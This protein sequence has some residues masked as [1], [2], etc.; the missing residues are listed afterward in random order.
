MKIQI[1][2]SIFYIIS[3]TII[4]NSKFSTH[5]KEKVKKLGLEKCEDCHTTKSWNE[6]KTPKEFDHSKTGF[7]LG[8]QHDKLDCSE[9][10]NFKEKISEKKECQSCHFDPHKGKAFVKVDANNKNCEECHKEVSWHQTERKHED[11]SKGYV[12]DGM[13]KDVSCISCHKT[14]NYSD[15]GSDCVSCHKTDYVKT[16]IPN[17][18]T[19]KF[20]KD[21]ETCHTT[22]GWTQARY[23]EHEQYFPILNGDHLGFTC[24]SCHQNQNNYKEYTCFNCHT[25]NKKDTNKQ[26][27]EVTG[28][29]FDSEACL[30]CHPQGKK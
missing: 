7:D 8:S 19:A 9:C 29:R 24:R 16:K 6:L 30:S 10:H 18:K 23:Y 25:H 26:H 22:Y 1:L 3:F 2:L 11:F 4:A 17:H 20:S 21:C 12:L 15:V 27:K 5:N 13:H 14:E 28:Y